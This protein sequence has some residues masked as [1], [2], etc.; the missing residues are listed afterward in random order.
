MF[1]TQA[2]YNVE[3][4]NDVTGSRALDT[5]Y[6]NTKAKTLFITVTCRC[7]KTLQAASAYFQGKI[8]GITTGS[9]GIESGLLNAPFNGYFCLVCPVKPQQTYEIPTTLSGDGSITLTSWIE[10]W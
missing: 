2:P 4:V 7:Q 3:N 6:T 1:N 5:P 10:S 8:G 9:A